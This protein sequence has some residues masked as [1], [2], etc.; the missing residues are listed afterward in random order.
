MD[1][2]RRYGNYVVFMIEVTCVRIRRLNKTLYTRDYA[3]IS[4]QHSKS[5]TKKIATTLFKKE[6]SHKSTDR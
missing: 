4:M 2:D 5:S 6:E 1:L 3:E